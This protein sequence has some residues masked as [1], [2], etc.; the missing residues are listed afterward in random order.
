MRLNALLETDGWHKDLG[1]LIHIW[2][3]Y[4]ALLMKSY[5]S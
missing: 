4:D 3:E 1:F 5:T 2:L